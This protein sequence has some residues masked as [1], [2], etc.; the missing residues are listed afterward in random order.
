MVE[1]KTVLPTLVC[2]LADGHS[3][4]TRSYNRSKRKGKDTKPELLVRRLRSTA[5]CSFERVSKCEISGNM[6]LDLTDYNKWIF[7]SIKSLIILNST[8]FIVRN[9]RLG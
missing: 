3:K 6:P 5:I 4:E 9:S 2:I 1:N 7:R 8:K